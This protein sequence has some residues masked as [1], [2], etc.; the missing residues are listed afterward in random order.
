M[1][2]R[3]QKC[4]ARLP[5]PRMLASEDSPWI[6]PNFLF[7][8]ARVGL[9]LVI[10]AFLEYPTSLPEKEGAAVGSDCSGQEYVCGRSAGGG[11]HRH[12]SEVFAE[13]PLNRIVVNNRDPTIC[14]QPPLIRAKYLQIDPSFGH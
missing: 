3:Y 9:F 14:T 10:S 1:L 12:R 6:I 13:K 5:N 4:I 11:S 2:A 7:M 8:A